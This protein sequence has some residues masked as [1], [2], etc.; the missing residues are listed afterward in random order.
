MKVKTF[1][2]QVQVSRQVMV[3]AE[4]G[5]IEASVRHGLAEALSEL[6][7]PRGGHY[8]PISEITFYDYME[9]WEDYTQNTVTYGATRD[10]RYVRPKR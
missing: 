8:E 7:G 2:A 10:G 9:T 5:A 3:Q 6:R 4:K 1:G